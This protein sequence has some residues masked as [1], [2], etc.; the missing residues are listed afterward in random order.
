MTIDPN[1]KYRQRNGT[2]VHRIL[3]TDF[4][5]TVL[6]VV[7]TFLDPTGTELIV[8][9]CS[10]GKHVWYDKSFP[11][12]YDLIEVEDDPNCHAQIDTDAPKET[13]S[14]LEKI[15]DIVRSDRNWNECEQ[16]RKKQ[17]AITLWCAVDIYGAE[18]YHEE[19]PT[20]NKSC[21]RWES[22]GRIF[23]LQHT[24]IAELAGK[25]IYSHH[26]PIELELRVKEGAK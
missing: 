24:T 13:V 20:F 2:P 14:A 8:R 5:C 19:K 18:Y 10:D 7:Y 1:K 16:E 6:T 23:E 25:N 17:S 15:I 26:E 21:G 4:T 11:H 22:G 12:E 9:A 3:C